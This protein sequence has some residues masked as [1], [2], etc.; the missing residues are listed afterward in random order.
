[1]NTDYAMQPVPN[2]VA[3][4]TAGRGQVGCGSRQWE[5]EKLA[6]KARLKY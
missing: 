6:N 3:S 4:V 1:M 5:Y 2:I